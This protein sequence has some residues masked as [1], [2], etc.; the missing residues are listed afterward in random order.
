MIIVIVIVV[1]IIIS[2]LACVFLVKSFKVGDCSLSSGS[3]TEIIKKGTLFTN[4]DKIP[5]TSMSCSAPVT[6]KYTDSSGEHEI[7]FTD[8]AV[9]T[10]FVNGISTVDLR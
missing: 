2:I 10:I 3:N 7:K 6:G 8:N 9:N 1:L 5:Y 4:T